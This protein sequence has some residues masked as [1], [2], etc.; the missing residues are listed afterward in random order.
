MDAIALGSSIGAPRT[1][2]Y[3]APRSPRFPSATRPLA[4]RARASSA[5]TPYRSL[6]AH[7]SRSPRRSLLTARAEEIAQPK[8]SRVTSKIC[9]ARKESNLRG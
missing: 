7:A 5:V 4:Y 1:R 2:S 3:S 6:L 9:V 8:K